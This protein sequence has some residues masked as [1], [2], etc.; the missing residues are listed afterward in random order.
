MIKTKI[1]IGL[2]AVCT[3][4]VSQSSRADTFTFDFVEAIDI[5]GYSGTMTMF[6]GNGD[7]LGGTVLGDPTGERGGESLVWA[8][9]GLTLTVTAAGNDFVYLDKNWSG[10]G[11]GGLGVT[12][13]LT[14]SNQAA[15]SSDDNVSFGEI[16]ELDF[17]TGVVWDLGATVFRSDNHSLY[18]NT[19]AGLP[20]GMQVQVDG[21]GWQN[22]DQLFGNNTLSLGG[23]FFEFQTID[24]P[25]LNKQFYIDTL[26]VS[27]TVPPGEITTPVPEPATIALIGIGL[28]GLAGAEVRRRRKKKTDDK[29]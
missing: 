29:S 24:D 7:P 18:T 14:S 25:D 6:G 9:D 10:H 19:L 4:F 23:Q 26:A 2:M 5:G 15:P 22:I 12:S 17:G 21:G 8:Q 1:L 27:T 11:P 3:F 13:I 20:D 16:L 28:T